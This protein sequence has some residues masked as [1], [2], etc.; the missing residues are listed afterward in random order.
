MRIISVSLLTLWMACTLLGITL[1]GS[2][3]LLALGAIAIEVVRHAPERPHAA[4]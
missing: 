1:A 3:H 4:H 2:I